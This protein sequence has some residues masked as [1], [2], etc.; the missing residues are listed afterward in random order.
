MEATRLISCVA[1]A[2]ISGFV[3]IA[4]LSRNGPTT[5][6]L[7]IRSLHFA[8][9]CLHWLASLSIVYDLLECKQVAHACDRMSSWSRSHGHILAREECCGALMAAALSSLALGVLWAHS[10]LGVMAPLAAWAIGLYLL[11]SSDER[12]RS[13]EL[14]GQMP[15]V[16]RTLAM[17]MGSGETLAQAVEYVGA[18]EGGPAGEAF[19]TAA[20]KL[21]C[22]SSAQEALSELVNDLDA[23]G[24]EL[25]ATA[26]LISQRTG[27][28]LRGLFQRSAAL[29]ERQGEFERL[30][31]VKTAQVRLSVRIVALL[32]VVMVGGLSLISPDFQRGVMTG[33][34]A[35]CL[36]V[37][38]V[39][40]VC[41]L[42][43]IRHLMKGVL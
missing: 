14:S 4:G 35:L 3:G 36:L 30:L 13:K 33:P 19:R 42:V 5:R 7:V 25:I 2:W 38:A 41:A 1:L 10:P 16:F 22:G 31:S 6:A 11:D 23:P 27:S 29:V 32:P 12:R 39:M 24:V 21:R 15:D 37:A 18:H 28:P 43:I 8:Q 20:L 17:A 40:D 9:R 34:G 26:L